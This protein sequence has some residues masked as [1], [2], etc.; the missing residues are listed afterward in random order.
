MSNIDYK[1]NEM[2]ETISYE[3]E[4]KTEK[5]L[6]I[7]TIAIVAITIISYIISLVIFN[8]MIDNQMLKWGKIF[9]ITSLVLSVVGIVLSIVRIVQAYEKWL[10]IISLIL[11]TIMGIFSIINNRF[12]IKS[13]YYD[14]EQKVAYYE[15]KKGYKVAKKIDNADVIIYGEINGKAVTKISSKF[16]SS[17][18]T[19][20]FQGGNWELKKKQFSNA[21]ALKKIIINDAELNVARKTFKNND[22]L[23]EVYINNGTLKTSFAK[24]Y[25]QYDESKTDI[26]IGSNVCI[27]LNNSSLIG[28]ADRIALLEMS[29]SS[30]INVSSKSIAG[31]VVIKDDAVLGESSISGN[32]PISYLIYLPVSIDIIPDN[33]FGSD[34]WNGGKEIKVYYEGTE[35]DWNKISIGAIGNQNYYRGSVK[36]IYNSKSK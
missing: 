31:K 12:N 13:V 32:T 17:V 25:Y 26:F 19:I 4:E 8:N 29:G 27:Y 33:F 16:G 5:M 7:G 21:T 24:A 1:I 14:S 36:I 18:Q 15:T 10:Y 20:T 35:E 34:Q 2:Q 28:L 3:E 11:L 22:Y 23:K 30:N 9:R 6:L